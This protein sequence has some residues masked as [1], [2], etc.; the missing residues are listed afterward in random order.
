MLERSTKTLHVDKKNQI[1][2][3]KT[4]TEKLFNILNI[5]IQDYSPPVKPNKSKSIRINFIDKLHIVS[6]V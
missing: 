6:V 5:S 4:I 2:V 1:I 3:R